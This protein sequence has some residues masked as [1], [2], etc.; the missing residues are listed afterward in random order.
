MA[1]RE[2]YVLA[3]LASAVTSHR[4]ELHQR[5]MT[6]SEFADWIRTSQLRDLVS[7]FDVSRFVDYA[8][9]NQAAELVQTAHALPRVIFDAEAF[10]VLGANI[11]AKHPLN[12]VRKLG[13]TWAVESLK[14]VNPRPVPSS[15][16]VFAP[17]V[18]VDNA[19]DTQP[20]LGFSQRAVGT[21]E[22]PPPNPADIVL[23]PVGRGSI[24]A[25]ASDRVVKLDHNRPE[26]KNL[27]V[28]LDDALRA[29]E[30]VNDEL[31]AE[32]I[33]HIF[34]LKAGRVYLESPQVDLSIVETT[35]IRA[36]RELGART[37]NNAADIAIQAALAAVMLYFFGVV[38]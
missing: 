16:Q 9:T 20:E 26:T 15:S 7:N 37:I 38:L 28:T 21:L 3:A 34:E 12:L 8:V 13:L 19:L 10:N 23:H 24:T 6:L 5:P 33:Q 22:N 11:N 31:P 25:P 2:E 17:T 29:L 14:N 4:A 36:L 18:A 32:V 35:L 30:G 27:L 1:S